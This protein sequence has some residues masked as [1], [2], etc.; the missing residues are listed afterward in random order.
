LVCLTKFHKP[1]SVN[2]LVCLTKFHQ[3][4]TQP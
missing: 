1:F 2:P 3:H 4:F